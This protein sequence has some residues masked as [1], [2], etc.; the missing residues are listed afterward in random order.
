MF[1]AVFFTLLSLVLL[2]TLSETM[3]LDIFGIGRLKAKRNFPE[4]AAKM[5][6]TAVSPERKKSF[7]D[8][9]GTY[10][11][12]D[13]WVA[14]EMSSVK[15][16]MPRLPGLFLNTFQQKISFE[17]GNRTVD[18]FFSARQAPADMAEKLVENER[19]VP[20]LTHFIEK[21]GR[22]IG[23]MDIEPGYVECRLK[24]GMG[25]YIPASLLEPMATD[26]VNLA[27]ALQL[28]I[29][30]GKKDKSDNIKE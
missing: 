17:T 7:S 28:S 30:P 20:L 4:A 22:K 27:D 29:G 18:R 24:F 2:W 10:G 25:H 26:L 15:V 19:V 16:I 13:I 8:Y 23:K 3:F 9:S 1:K 11:G 14:P 12:Y 5:G 21:W 6:L